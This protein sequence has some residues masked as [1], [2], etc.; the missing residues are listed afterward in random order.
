MEQLSWTDSRL[1]F[2]PALYAIAWCQSVC[3][4][5]KGAL[6]VCFSFWLRVLD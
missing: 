1:P 4:S 5:V 6:F 3:L 2:P